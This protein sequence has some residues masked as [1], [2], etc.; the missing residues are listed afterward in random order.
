[1]TYSS[2]ISLMLIQLVK[3]IAIN[4]SSFISFTNPLTPSFPPLFNPQ[5][6]GSPIKTKFA[7]KAK[8]LSTSIPLLKPPSIYISIFYPYLSLLIFFTVFAICFKTE[9][10]D[11]TVSKIFPPPFDIHIALAPFYIANIA[12]SL[13]IIPFITIGKLF[14]NYFIYFISSNLK[15]LSEN[16]FLYNESFSYSPRS[17]VNKLR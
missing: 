9:I 11:G 12:S 2:V 6:I 15:Y 14:D 10:V 7:P 17:L 16:S 13:H 3:A 8:A 1:M 4:N 5:Y